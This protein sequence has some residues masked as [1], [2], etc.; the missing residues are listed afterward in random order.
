VIECHNWRNP[1]TPEI[2]KGFKIKT[3][4]QDEVT[5]AESSVLQIDATYYTSMLLDDSLITYDL[6][7]VYPG[8]YSTYTISFKSEVPLDITDGCY[9]KYTFPKEIDANRMDLSSISGK[10]LFLDSDGKSSSSILM[11]AMLE[12]TDHEDNYIILEGCKF[13]PSGKTDEDL[14][15]F[16]V[17]EFIVSISNI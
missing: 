16:S 8:E 5:T 2:F 14:Q 9:V 12:N 15:N 17:D 4:H 3:A 6:D 7:V 1:L 11:V 10:G 13:D